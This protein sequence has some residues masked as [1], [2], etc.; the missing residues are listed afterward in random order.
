MVKCTKCR[1]GFLSKNNNC[2][3]TCEDIYYEDSIL[4][5]CVNCKTK[6]TKFK[7]LG[8]DNSCID[9]PSTPYYYIN[10]E[11]GVIGMC[12]TSCLTCNEAPTT[13]K[14]N[15]A[16]CNSGEYLSYGTKNCDTSCTSLYAISDDGV[17]C[18]KCSDNSDTTKRFKYENIIFPANTFS[19]TYIVFLYQFC[20][21]Y[22]IKRC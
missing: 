4:K 10:T 21:K 19:K 17:S 13:G 14:D 3:D 5:E 15:C 16:S 6:Y 11:A 18:V 2:I 9:E 8:K 12:G 7:K 22:F 1:K 20:L